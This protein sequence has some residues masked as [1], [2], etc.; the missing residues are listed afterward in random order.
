MFGGFNG[1]DLRRWSLGEDLLER[2][3]IRFRL[4]HKFSFDEGKTLIAEILAKLIFF[5]VT[6]SEQLGTAYT[7][8]CEPKPG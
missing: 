5:F 6:R 7:V 1:G 8:Q 4:E 3:H 2:C